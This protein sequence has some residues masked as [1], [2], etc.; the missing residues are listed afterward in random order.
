L[1][2]VH[3]DELEHELAIAFETRNPNIFGDDHVVLETMNREV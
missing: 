2:I 3:Q 1:L